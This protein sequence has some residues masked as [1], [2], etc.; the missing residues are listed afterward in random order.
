MDRALK[1][2]SDFM[3]Q[4]QRE[5]TFFATKDVR[6]IN[7]TTDISIV[8]LPDAARLRRLYLNVDSSISVDGTNY[9]IFQLVAYRL[10]TPSFATK[11]GLQPDGPFAGSEDFRTSKYPITA[12]T[13]LSVPYDVELEKDDL[14]VLEV[15]KTLSASDLTTF[16]VQADFEPR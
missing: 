9:W 4:Q 7:A 1:D 2:L 12:Y 16:F 15:T 10:G 3:L 6:T 14:V 13:G 11:F 8:C 5:T